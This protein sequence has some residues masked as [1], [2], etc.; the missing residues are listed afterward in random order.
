[1]KLKILDEK[2]QEVIN[3]DMRKQ[4]SYLLRRLRQ[5]EQLLGHW[6]RT[7]RKEYLSDLRYKNKGKNG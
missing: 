4:R 2:L 3:L 7:F 1:V 5:E 6:Y